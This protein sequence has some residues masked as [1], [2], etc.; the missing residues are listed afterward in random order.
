MK[1]ETRL[2]IATRLIAEAEGLVVH[3]EM[4]AKELEKAGHNPALA[5]DLLR[6]FEQ[7]HGQFVRTAALLES[8]C[9]W[10]K[11]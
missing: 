10:I 4:L 2:E 3:Q 1:P 6:Q 11:P 8:Q 5:R 9:P 7:A